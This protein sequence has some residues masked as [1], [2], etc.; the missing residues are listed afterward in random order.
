[1][2]YKLKMNVG[3]PSQNGHNQSETVY[4][5]SNKTS[6]ELKEFIKREKQLFVR[7]RLTF[8]RWVIKCA[9]LLFLVNLSQKLTDFL[10]GE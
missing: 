10:L 7:D 8:G 1:M 3:D 6:K 2:K 9:L 4:F 5:M